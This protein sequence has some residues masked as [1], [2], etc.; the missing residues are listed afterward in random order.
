MGRGVLLSLSMVVL[1][2][3]HVFTQAAVH[4]SA[5]HDYRI[6]TVAEGLVNPWSIAFLPDGDML[7]TER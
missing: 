1:I 6:V 2:A 4:Q 5:H 7:I 3:G